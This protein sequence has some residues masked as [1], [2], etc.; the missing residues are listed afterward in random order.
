VLADSSMT[1]SSTV[2]LEGLDDI[3]AAISKAVR[4]LRAMP[5]GK[6]RDLARAELEHISAQLAAGRRTSDAYRDFDPAA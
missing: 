4:L 5:D 1:I 3:D 2:L 6:A